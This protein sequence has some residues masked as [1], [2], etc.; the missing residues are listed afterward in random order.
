MR[1]LRYLSVAFVLLS[2]SA[3]SVQ[4]QSEIEME[5]DAEQVRGLSKQIGKIPDFRM[6]EGV[7]KRIG[8][9]YDA[10]QKALDGMNQTASIKATN[11]DFLNAFRQKYAPGE[12][13]L[14]KVT[15]LLNEKFRPLDLG[16][17]VGDEYEYV[18]TRISYL[19]TAGEENAMHI[20]KYVRDFA[21]DPSMLKNLHEI[22][23]V[24]AIEEAR[25]LL[26][27]AG[28]FAPGNER[29]ERRV[30]RLATE[31]ETVLKDFREEE[32]KTLQS[33]SWK[34]NIGSTSAG[35]PAAL[36]AAG[37]KFMTG[38]PDWGG[39]TA[40]GTVIKKVSI[41]GDW[42]VAE[43][44]ALGRPTR[45]GLPAAVAVR[46]NT[47]DPGVVTVYEVSLI[48]K[49]PKMDTNFFGVW[50]GNVWRMLDKNLPK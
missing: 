49:H 35:A 42:F 7:S 18:M 19:D 16:Y 39:N 46:D 24:K 20:I 48:T 29:V 44:D 32:M 12:K 43:R 22:Y 10:Y 6:P 41:I 3:F 50:V 45:Y 15:R 30:D 28:V 38:L 4:A 11:M 2:V 47:M 33:R 27:L 26:T 37:H 8:E 1:I 9:N 21:L 13:E 40:K 14:Y 17:D 25:T 23:R 31:A 34:G 5:D 36:A